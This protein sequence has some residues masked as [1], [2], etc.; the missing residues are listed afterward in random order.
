M[1]NS[2]FECK[3]KLLKQMP[4]GTEKRVTE[5]YIMECGSFTQAEAM[6][7]QLMIE[8]DAKDFEVSDISKTK[9]SDV[10]FSDSQEP[11]TW[12]KCKLDI[13]TLDE[14]TGGEKK[15]SSYSLIEAK[16]VPDAQMR[17][18]ERMKGITTDYVNNSVVET[19]VLEVVVQ[20][21]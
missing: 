8:L 10:V 13:F 1:I 17:L 19:K 16:D 3:V 6:L 4:N 9:Y 14:R 11:T 18:K 15:T 12:F 5:S 20:D 7:Y 2:W 21:K